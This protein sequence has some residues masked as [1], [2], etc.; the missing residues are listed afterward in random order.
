MKTS[1]A[2]HWEG[3]RCKPSL[4]LIQTMAVKVDQKTF[5][6]TIELRETLVAYIAGKLHNDKRDLIF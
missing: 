3:G 6:L 2:E 1:T 4:E 5:L